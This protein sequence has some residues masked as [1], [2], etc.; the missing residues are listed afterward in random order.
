MS[1]RRRRRR[2]TNPGEILRAEFLEPLGLTQRELADHLDCDIKVVNRIV[3]GSRVTVS[4]AMRLA[5]A[6]GTTPEFWLTLQM[7]VD[8]YEA[9]VRDRY[10]P[11]RIQSAAPGG[12]HAPRSS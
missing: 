8:L 6:L 7:E 2:P 5:S 11:G 3:N 4:M 1:A 10:L 12:S 9:Q